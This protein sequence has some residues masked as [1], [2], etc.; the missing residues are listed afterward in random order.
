MTGAVH[1]ENEPAM[2]AMIP[3]YIQGNNGSNN[4]RIPVA[5]PT[6]FTNLQPN[7]TYRY[8][9]QFVV[10]DDGQETAGAGNV[11]YV[12]PEGFYRSTSPSLA[13]EGGYG[14]FTT[15]MDGS[16]LV[17]FMNE[18]TANA[19]FTPGNHVFMRVRLNDGNDGTTVEHI[20]TSEDY[21]TVLNFG[22][23]N[24]EYS[25]SAF[26]VK[27]AEAPMNFALMYDVDGLRPF[28]ATSIETTGVDYGNINQYANFYKE[29]VAGNDGWF[30]G[31]LPNINENGLPYILIVGMD[32]MPVREYASEDGGF[33]YPNANTVN[34]TYGLD[35]PI[36]ID[37]T[38]D[39]VEE[40]AEVNVKVWSADHE[41]VV[42]NGDD[43]HYTMT[44]YNM[45]GQS[46]MQ[47]QINAGSTQRISHNLSN[48]LYIISLQNNQNMVS[49]KVIVR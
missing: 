28:Y 3:L 26:Y 9:N 18:S 30:G 45:L 42:E 19:R 41:F 2:N 22:N 14:E 21:A 31:I 25:G 23:E 46:M 10:S 11:I 40:L 35:E 44:V 33:W 8:T 16:A 34:P 48:G 20:F 36:F 1:S 27:S 47:K 6:R 43:A 4:N 5:I 15:G 37:L 49:H 7:T 39:D 38:Y 13:T 29:F 24:D 12:N 17:W 32:F